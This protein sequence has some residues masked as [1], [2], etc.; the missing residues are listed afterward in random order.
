MCPA[1]NGIRL[2]SLLGE[3]HPSIL[4]QNAN[5][6]NT[7]RKEGNAVPALG[8]DRRGV[9]LCAW[10][11]VYVVS[12][13]KHL[14]H[15]RCVGVVG[16]LAGV[17]GVELIHLLWSEGKVKNL[18]VLRH[19]LGIGGLGQ[20]DAPLLYLKAQGESARLCLAILLPQSGDHRMG[21][22][23]RASVAQGEVGLQFGLLLGHH[24]PQF[25]LLEK[26]G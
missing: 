26:R 5:P 13:E 25:P 19:V 14:C 21:E 12:G 20:D 2:H 8:G 3:W 9:P 24:R 22:Q 16:T 10:L 7:L 23:G 1:G 11:C 17:Q 18:Q 6:V 15:P 4:A